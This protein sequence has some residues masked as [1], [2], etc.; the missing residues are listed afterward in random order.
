MFDLDH[1]G[2]GGGPRV[3][4]FVDGLDGEDSGFF[5]SE[6]AT[7]L[8]IEIWVGA[9]WEGKLDERE[10]VFGRERDGRA[11]RGADC[12]EMENI[13]ASVETLRYLFQ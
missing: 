9:D 12:A 1:P 4:D 7:A 3:R 10:R 5:E 8:G 13:G 11:P 2:L 6:V